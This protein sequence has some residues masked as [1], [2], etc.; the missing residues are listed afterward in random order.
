MLPIFCLNNFLFPFF[1]IF[2]VSTNQS[3]FSPQPAFVPGVRR[4]VRGCHSREGGQDTLLAGLAP[5]SQTVGSNTRVLHG[6]KKRSSWMTEAKGVGK[7]KATCNSGVWESA[8][9]SAA[10][11]NRLADLNWQ[12]VTQTYV[13]IITIKSMF[14]HS[15]QCPLYHSNFP[16]YSIVK[17][18]V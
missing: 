10:R 17:R 12:I 13:M 2:F 11:E 7:V 5:S 4:M 3:L 14:C 6:Q 16:N 18:L 8:F 15:M 1:K 9:K